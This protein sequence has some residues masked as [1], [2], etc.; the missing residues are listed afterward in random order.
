MGALVTHLLV[1]SQPRPIQLNTNYL[2]EFLKLTLERK[3]E[4]LEAYGFSFQTFYLALLSMCW[5]KADRNTSTAKRTS[6]LLMHS[7]GAM[8]NV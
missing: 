2:I 3:W 6:G 5:I 1:G 4:V 7:E 8:R